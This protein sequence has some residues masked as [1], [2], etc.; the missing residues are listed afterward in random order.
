MPLVCWAFQEK[1]TGKWFVRP[2]C[3][4]PKP[5]DSLFSVSFMNRDSRLKINRRCKAHV[6]FDSDVDGWEE[7]YWL[8]EDT[9]ED[10]KNPREE[11][12][13]CPLAS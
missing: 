4:Y 8:T 6:V 3:R 10:G 11:Y 7:H 1:N 12:Q 9:R 5:G 13:T 2:L